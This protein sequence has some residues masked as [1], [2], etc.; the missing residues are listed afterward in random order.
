MQERERFCELSAIHQ[1]LC[2]VNNNRQKSPQASLTNSPF[3]IQLATPELENLRGFFKHIKKTHNVC[4]DM[5]K[6]SEFI[7]QQAVT[8]SS[9]QAAS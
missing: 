5:T 6:A 4:Y 8:S 9:R 1:K 3:N 7:S 2:L